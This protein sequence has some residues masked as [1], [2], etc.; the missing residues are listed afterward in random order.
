MAPL[1][2]KVHLEYEDQKDCKELSVVAPSLSK[3]VKQAIFSMVRAVTLARQE[4]VRSVCIAHS[5][6]VQ[7]TADA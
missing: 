2:H 7:E 6:A 5:A 3:L 1:A 4:V